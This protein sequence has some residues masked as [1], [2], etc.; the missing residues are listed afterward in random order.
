MTVKEELIQNYQ[1][2]RA[3]SEELCAPL[4]IEDYV[5][6]SIPDVSPPKWHLAHTSWFF[7]NF[8]LKDV[9]PH[10]QFFNSTFHYLFNSYYY[11]M[12]KFYPR[13]KRGLLARPSTELIYSYRHYIDEQM[14]DLMINTAEINV[15][16]I[17]NLIILGLEHEQQHQELLLMDIKYNFYID[18]SFPSYQSN[19]SAPKVESFARSASIPLIEV[20]GGTVDIGYSEQGFCF[21]NELPCHKKIIKPYLIAPHLV[22][23][24]DYLEFIND[25][26]YREPRWWLSDGWDYCHQA[27]WQSPLY[28]IK[29]L[30]SWEQF[31]LNGLSP[32]VLSEPVCHLSYYEAQ[33]YANWRGHRLPLEEEWEHFVRL[34]AFSPSHG[35]FMENRF[36][37]PQSPITSKRSHPIQF[38][39]DLWEWTSSAY[40]PYPGY[41]PFEGKLGEYNGKFM[42][43]QIILKGG[44]CTTP[45]AHIRAS[46]RNFFQPEKRW[47]FSG[48]RLAANLE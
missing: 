4:L 20:T 32:L 28:W 13:H 40:L 34:S 15:E 9:L 17:T 7:E 45:R 21:D 43:N 39:G 8:I 18:P 48:L 22:T 25:G 46:Y 3:R 29:G 26:G 19:L 12:G 36:F 30:H 38:F 37:H 10:Y 6:Q 27:G 14:L 11:G 2:L 1:N 47:Q 31:T 44:S 42:N 5:I 16:K 41:Q 24:Q 35:N 33:A 23:N